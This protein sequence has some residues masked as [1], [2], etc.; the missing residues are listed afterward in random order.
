MFLKAMYLRS[1][2]DELSISVL[3]IFPYDKYIKLGHLG[4]YLHEDNN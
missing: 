3:V 1:L 2:H 4:D